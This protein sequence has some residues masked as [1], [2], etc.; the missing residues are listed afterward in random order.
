MSWLAKRMECGERVIPDTEEEKM[1]FQLVKDLDHVSGHVKG[2]ITSKKYM[3]NE[4]WSLIS[5]K[6]SLLGLSHFLLLIINIQYVFTT[7][8]Y[9]KNLI[10]IYDETT[11][12]GLNSSLA[13][14]WLVP[15]SFILFVNSL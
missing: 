1:C 2:S 15:V 10:R 6:G 12:L 5:F 14:L 4:L 13:T 3:R 7:Q 8:I 9:K 11:I